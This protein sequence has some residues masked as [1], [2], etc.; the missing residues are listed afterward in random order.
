M[1]NESLPELL[2]MYL[3]HAIRQASSASE[4]TC[5]RGVSVEGE[6]GVDGR[7]NLLE[8]VR[9]KVGAEWEVID[10]CLLAA[11]IVDTDLGVWYTTAVARLDVWLVL[12]VAVALCWTCRHTKLDSAFGV[13]RWDEWCCV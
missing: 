4:D 11:K 1:W 9:H 8:L 2:V 3:L 13:C 7:S 6:R 10:G 5:R 12:L